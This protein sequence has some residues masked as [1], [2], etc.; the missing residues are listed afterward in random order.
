MQ[1]DEGKVVVP[2]IQE[3]VHTDARPVQTGSVRVTKSVA[4][5]DEL[6]EQEL[7]KGRADVKRIQVNRVVDGPQE[8]Y[9]TGNTL[10]IPVVS[11]VLQGCE[12]QWLLT[13]EV[14]I[15]QLEETHTV[16]QTVPV[17]EEHVRVERLDAQGN[18]IAADGE[19]QG[20]QARVAERPLATKPVVEK[21]SSEDPLSQTTRT[22]MPS[23]VDRSKTAAAPAK[24]VLSSP[25]SILSKRSRNPERKP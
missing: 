3:E 2:V 14:H 7:R 24:K 5:R 22:A 25:K 8:P 9:R 23:I 15:T 19:A 18:V 6:I 21:P 17:S 20:V 16:Q 10:V 4:T 1:K 12:K 11:E 13:E